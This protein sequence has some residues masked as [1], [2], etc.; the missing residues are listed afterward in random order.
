MGA[1]SLL[2]QQQAA[3]VTGNNL[4]NV[5]NKSYARQQ[6]VIQTSAPLPTPVGP[7]GTGVDAIGIKQ[8]RDG[9]LDRQV[10]AQTSDTSSLT[11]QQS[12]LQN[13]EAYLN[14]QIQNSSATNTPAGSSTG[15]AST[16]SSLFS[17]LQDLSLAPTGLAERQTVVATAQKLANQFNQL[18]SQLSTVRDGAN[19]SIQTDVD[20]SNQDLAA[21]AALNGQISNAIASGGSPNSLIDQ[22]QEKL[23]DLASKVNITTST[24]ANGA[25]DVSIGGVA[26]VSGFQKLDQLQAFDAGGG[27]ILV[28]AQTAGT[29]LDLTGGSIG[30]NITAR[31]GALADLQ[32]GLDTLASNLAGSVNAI[33]SGATGQDFFTGDTAASLAVSAALVADP[34]TLQAG[35]LTPGDNSIAAALAALSHQTIAGLKGQTFSQSYAATVTSL[36]TSIATVSDQLTNSQAVGQMLSNQRSSVSGVNMDE[37]MTNL[38]QYQKAYQA[39]AELISTIN[40]MLQTVINMKST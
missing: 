9:F 6:A 26:M 15:I 24:E 5:N 22:R 19:E 37:E 21:I 30:G 20:A 8:F 29:T 27:Q 39:S 33:Y 16:L 11:A 13:A 17:S 35:V 28:Q 31:D 4:A 3:E 38:L 34:S 40:S 1:R 14:E 2:A 36:G 32:N 23:E 7:E 25:I 12:A 18:A 10:T